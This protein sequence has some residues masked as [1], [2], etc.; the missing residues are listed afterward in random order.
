MKR[1]LTTRCISI[2]LLLDVLVS[3]LLAIAV[4]ALLGT[5]SYAGGYLVTGVFAA[6]KILVWVL[7]L[8][9]YLEPYERFQRQ[10]S[11]SRTR[12]A[13]LDADR[14]ILR[15]PIRFAVSY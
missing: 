2:F 3:A 9:R 6:A 11:G 13:L 12:A 7:L 5:A 14:A 15:F 8:G 1:S 10:P 4:P